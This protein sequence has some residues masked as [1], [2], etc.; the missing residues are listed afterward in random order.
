FS[1]A[2]GVLVS[3]LSWDARQAV[4]A[5]LLLLLIL[6]GLPPAAAGVIAYFTPNNLVLHQLFFSCPFYTL[7]NAFETYYRLDPS[8]YLWSMAVIHAVTWVLV[9]LA[10]WRAPNSWQDRVATR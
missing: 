1:L 5:N 8:R 10:S 4:G 7:F 9:G 2:I 3:V 6:A